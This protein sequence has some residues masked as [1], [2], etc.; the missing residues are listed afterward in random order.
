MEQIAT[1]DDR[2]YG[3]KQTELRANQYSWSETG[4]RAEE[5]G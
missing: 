4:F 3:F 1:L 5:Y 2:P